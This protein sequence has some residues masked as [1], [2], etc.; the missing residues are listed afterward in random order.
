MSTSAIHSPTESLTRT[1][2]S[3][4]AK[5]LCAPCRGRAAPIRG[6]CLP[7]TPTNPYSHHSRL[8]RP[9]TPKIHNHVRPPVPVLHAPRATTQTRPCIFDCF[10]ACFMGILSIPIAEI[11]GQLLISA[12]TV[13]QW[14]GVGCL[15]TSAATVESGICL[16][17]QDA[18]SVERDSHNEIPPKED[19]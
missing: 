15:W 7:D 18:L 13:Q 14:S 16:K 3:R 11:E 5:Y 12:R 1:L 10:Q 8:P 2:A 4:S 17:S 19:T 6:P 9:T